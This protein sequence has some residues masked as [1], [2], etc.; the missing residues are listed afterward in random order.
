MK[1]LIVILVVMG[2]VCV[3]EGTDPAFAR[4]HRDAPMGDFSLWQIAI[5]VIILLAFFCG[6]SSQSKESIEKEKNASWRAN[7]RTSGE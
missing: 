1:R 2:L 3:F 7:W 4:V 5:G 6:W